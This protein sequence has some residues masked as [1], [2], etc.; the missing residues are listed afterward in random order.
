MSALKD[1]LTE[2]L[3]LPAEL[4]DA[5][6]RLT[7]TGGEQ[8]RIEQHKGIVSFA[9]EMIEVR[10]GKLRLRLRGE[11]LEISAMDREEL[12]ISGTVDAVELERG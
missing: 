11:G 5:V 6:F 10:G 12:L 3:L 9:P 4:Q 7:L 2:R 8:V 1:K